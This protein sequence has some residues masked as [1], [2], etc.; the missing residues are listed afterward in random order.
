MSTFFTAMKLRDSKLLVPIV[1]GTIGGVLVIIIFLIPVMVFITVK[2]RIRQLQKLKLTIVT[3]PS[4]C[5]TAAFI[6]D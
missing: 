3:T 4:K 5:L 1:G 6:L 2:C